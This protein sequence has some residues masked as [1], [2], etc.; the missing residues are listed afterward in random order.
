MGGGGTLHRFEGGYPPPPLVGDKGWGPHIKITKD[1]VQAWSAVQWQYC[2]VCKI[3][4][5]D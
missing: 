1:K 4:L 5:P 2:P 3:M